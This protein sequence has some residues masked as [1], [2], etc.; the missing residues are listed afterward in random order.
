MNRIRLPLYLI[1]CGV[2]SACGTAPTSQPPS[3]V[4]TPG[5]EQLLSQAASAQPI[6][7]AKLKLEAARLLLALQQKDRAMAIL[8]GIDTRVLPPSLAFDIARLRANQALDQHDSQTALRYLDRATLPPSMPAEQQL[9]L[10][11]LRANAY[12]QQSDP[13][14]ATRA[15]IAA[16]QLAQDNSQRQALHDQIW[17][18]LQSLS[19][20]ALQQAASNP[21]NNYYEQGWF[22]LAQDMRGSQDLASS[23][24]GL[25]QWRALWQQH[26]AYSLPPTALQQQGTA[27]L[28][29]KRIGLLLPLTGP[30]ANPARAISEGFFAALYQHSQDAK[31]A[32]TARPKVITIDS[33]KINDPA[34]LFALAKQQHLDLI[35]GPLARSFVQQISQQPNL[36]VPVLALNQTTD[37]TT[38][39]YQLDLA[40]EQE[41][42]LVAQRAWSDGHRRVALITPDAPWGNRLQQTL[43][44]KFE[45][46]GGTVVTELAYKPD[47]DLSAQISTLLLTDQSSARS[48]AIRRILGHSIKTQERPRDDIDAILMTALPQEARQIKPTLAFHFAGEVPVYATS[49]LYEGHPDPVRDVD[50]N[51]IIF[52]DLPW[53]L[54]PPSAEHQALTATRTD[55]DERFGRL[56]ALGIDAF[57]LYPYLPQ[58]K[59]NP[60][61]FFSGET[62]KLTLDTHLHISR[63]L[64][65]AQFKNGV[66]VLMDAAPSDTA[67]DSQGGQNVPATDTT[68]PKT[69]QT[70]GSTS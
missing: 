4:T 38:L 20:D 65:W 29:A 50:L 46:L 54:D 61:A 51:G 12:S 3:T 57:N 5:A 43:A 19:S 6:E 49:H 14:A 42:T 69:T 56:Y 70:A 31:S 9:E 34:T 22:E 48:H 21:S 15:L 62:G 32:D 13:V 7:S 60:G 35:V 44:D 53:A 58:M 52:C 59:Q 2:L 16:A 37:G 26:P 63:N 66:P 30:L 8:D 17:Q 18:T 25:Q 68:R 55:T 41:A 24:S 64:P 28:T 40:S 27:Q 33:T 39:P 67:T 23:N 47:Q 45:A 10:N 11:Q 36:P 1:L